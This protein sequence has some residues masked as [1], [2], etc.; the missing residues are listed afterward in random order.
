VVPINQT[1]ATAFLL[2]DFTN[3]QNNKNWAVV[4]G[5][6]AYKRI[7]ITSDQL[8]LFTQIAWE[9]TANITY[10]Y[11]AD[12]FT[13]AF[14]GDSQSIRNAATLSGI[15][16]YP[17]ITQRLLG[18]PDAVASG[19]PSTGFTANAGITNNTY[20]GRAILGTNGSNGDLIIHNAYRPINYIVVQGSTNDN[21]DSTGAQ[22]GGQAPAAV[23]AAA[24]TFFQAVRVY[25]PTI[26]IFVTGVLVAASR[27]AS[28]AQIANENAVA[29]AVT[30]QVA[31]G[32]ELIFFFPIS[33]AANNAAPFFTGTG[34]MGAPTGSGNSDW[35]VNTDG[36][37]LN[38]RGHY[39]YANWL[40]DQILAVANQYP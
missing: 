22:N 24:L 40:K 33:T 5:G 32:D 12:N 11:N 7:R 26:P 35:N 38:T 14:V 1:G 17:A 6:R 20:L 30:Q 28:A 37:H 9:P 18:L 10:P 13:M 2:L 21:N 4:E 25:F 34:N 36:V 39:V 27:P 8:T 16:T 31:A 15:D 23:Q 29:A 3:V 19:W